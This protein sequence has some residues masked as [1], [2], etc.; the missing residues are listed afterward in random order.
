MGLFDKRIKNAV[1]SQL[2][3]K[4]YESKS[5][6]P[7]FLV[8][9]HVGVKNKI[10]VQDWGYMYGPRGYRWGGRDISVQQYS[11]GTLILDVVDPRTKQLIW[12]G[13]A[14]GVVDP[15][16]SP[17]KKE[18]KLSEAVSKILGKFPPLAQTS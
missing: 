11:E 4:G 3:A 16:A 18:R 12:R 9:Y 7:D 14:Q 10:D 17:E 6:N 1:N 13:V 2:V 8:V 5:I 15:G